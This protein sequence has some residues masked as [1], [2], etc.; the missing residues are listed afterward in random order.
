LGNITGR[1]RRNIRGADSGVCEALRAEGLQEGV[2]NTLAK[3]AAAL[4]V[5]QGVV[6][7]V[8]WHEV[9]VDEVRI[10]R[11][12]KAVVQSERARRGGARREY[13]RAES[14]VHVKSELVAKR[15]G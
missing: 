11:V 8:S 13:V 9:L 2:V 4:D 15:G 5:D 3:S 1:K 14:R 6:L 12:V 7:A 10:V